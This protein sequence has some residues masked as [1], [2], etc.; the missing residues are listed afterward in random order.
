MLEGALEPLTTSLQPESNPLFVPCL[1]VLIKVSISFIQAGTKSSSISRISLVGPTDPTISKHSES[2]FTQ[3][4][5]SEEFT[6]L[7]DYT[8]RKS[9]HL[10]SSYSCQFKNNSEEYSLQKQTLLVCLTY[11]LYNKI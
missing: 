4:A 1:C 7:I 6:S 11:N 9:Y 2:P 5:E 8:V 3:T 10:S